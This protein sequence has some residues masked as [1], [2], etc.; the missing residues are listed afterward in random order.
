MFKNLWIYDNEAQVIAL[1]RPELYDSL[2][3][4]EKSELIHMNDFEGLAFAVIDE[5]A[6]AVIEDLTGDV[7]EEFKSIDEFIAATLAYIRA[8]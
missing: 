5:K 6:V 2:T 1:H 7:I 4:E 8:E 3:E